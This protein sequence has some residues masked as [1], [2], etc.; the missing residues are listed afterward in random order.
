MRCDWSDVSFARKRASVAVKSPA[1][2]RHVIDNATCATRRPRPNRPNDADAPPAATEAF[3]HASRDR[4]P[5]GDDAHGEANQQRQQRRRGEHAGIRRHVR[6]PRKNEAGHEGRPHASHDPPR[7]RHR[8]GERHGRQ[9][10]SVQQQ[11]PEHARRA[12][13]Q[14]ETNR[15]L[16]PPGQRARQGEARK[17]GARDRQQ[18]RHQA[19]EHHERGAVPGGESP[20]ARRERCHVQPLTEQRLPLGFRQRGR[21]R[22]RLNRRPAREQFRARRVDG[23]AARETPDHAS[24]SKRPWTG[25]SWPLASARMAR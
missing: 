3:V 6:K 8:T 23:H 15:D 16:V 19:Q 20:I 5:R 1:P 11:L 14:C 13:T 17:V 4:L 18:H 9:Q 22:R 7:Q 21:Q 25:P 2:T 24:R 10:D 12:S